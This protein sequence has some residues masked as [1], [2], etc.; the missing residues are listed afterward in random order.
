MIQTLMSKTSKTLYR[1]GASGSD[2]RTPAASRMPSR[3]YGPSVNPENGR[4]NGSS[5][6][7]GSRRAVKKSSKSKLWSP[8][9]LM[10]LSIVLGI[11]GSMYLTHVF[12]TQNTLRE[13]QQL[14][15]EY[16]RAHRLHTEARRNFERITGPAEVYHRAESIGM[17]SGG[18][19]DP[20]IVIER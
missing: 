12:E 15:R 2:T 9:K 14:R 3:N 1:S 5:N 6:G 17:I 8:W 4:K 13:V 18:P 10:L 19:S 16:E 11:A 7:S 20:V